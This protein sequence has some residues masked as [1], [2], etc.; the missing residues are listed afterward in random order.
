MSVVDLAAAARS[1]EE[2]AAHYAQQLEGR[3][4]REVLDFA[5]NELWPGRMAIVSSFGAESAVLLHVLST[6]DRHAPVI[7]LET[8][9]HFAQTLQYRDDLVARL[10]LTN[11]IDQKPDAEEA[12][13]EDARGDLWRRDPD[14]CCA[15]RKVRPLSA[16]LEGYDAWVTGRKRFQGGLRAALA[17]IEHDGV[18]YKVN[19]L[20]AWKA[21]EIAA[22]MAANDLPQHPLVAQ[23]F[24]S[25][26]CWPCTKP[27]A[28]QD[29][30]GRWADIEKTECGIHLPS[31]ARVKAL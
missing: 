7:F 16:A 14:A 19:P 12:K 15:L 28:A 17:L 3:T 2:R 6:I 10:G 8:D 24:P 11:V 31:P 9:R 27:A 29:R 23:G 21:E 22:Y 13:A 26:G 18:H 4:A 30:S 25:I 20:A 5:L 1:P